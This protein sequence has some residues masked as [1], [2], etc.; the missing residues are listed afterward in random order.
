MKIFEWIVILHQMEDKSVD[1][2]A[3]LE[4][5]LRALNEVVNLIIVNV[6]AYR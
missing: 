1:T 4:S 3:P 6:F 2:P 5:T